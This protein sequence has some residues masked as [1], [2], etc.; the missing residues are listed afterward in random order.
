[1]IRRP[2]QTTDSL[3]DYGKWY[4]K[5]D[6][7]PS[8]QTRI[9]ATSE[10]SDVPGPG[11]VLR[12]EVRGFTLRGYFNGD[13]VLEATDAD[14]SKLV[15]GIPGLAARWAAGNGATDTAVQVWE[16]WSGGSL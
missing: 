11:D 5:H 3:Q 7:V 1:M 4:F 8:D 2:A 12:V 15:N 9:I 13:L 6:G 14:S 16:S 10:A